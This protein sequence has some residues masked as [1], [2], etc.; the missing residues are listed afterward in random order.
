VLPSEAVNVTAVLVATDEVLTV[1]DTE[2]APAG[3]VTEF[4]TVAAM[5]FDA[6]L[7]LSPPEPTAPFAVTVPVAE[8][9]PTTELGVT[10]RPLKE[11]GVIV[12]VAEAVLVPSLPLIVTV[13]SLATA[14]VEI[15][16]VSE[17]S[18][19]ATSTF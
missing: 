3:I 17:V 4:G 19:S 8:T 13:V 14:V 5:L 18:P 2:V 6:R 11:L 12:S 10:V 16:N 9:P 7:I 15:V 1:N